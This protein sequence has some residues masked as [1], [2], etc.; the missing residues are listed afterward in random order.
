MKLVTERTDVSFWKFHFSR[1][2][3]AEDV[4]EYGRKK[5]S[6]TTRPHPSR[7]EACL[8]RAISPRCMRYKRAN[9]SRVAFS[10]SSSFFFLPSFSFLLQL[11][12]YIYIV[13]DDATT[14]AASVDEAIYI[15]GFIQPGCAIGPRIS[16]FKVYF[17]S[18]VSFPRDIGYDIGP[19]HGRAWK[20]AAYGTLFWSFRLR[21]PRERT[22]I[23]P[24]PADS[25]AEIP[26]N[27][28]IFSSSVS[29][30]QFH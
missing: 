19:E 29:L 18:F 7:N 22:P 14:L 12:I 30:L 5:N 11:N 2:L 20:M 3:W 25:L 26:F 28:G 23:S 15:D 16:I 27:N 8:S 13:D 6:R 9:F 1:E 10:P 21:Q 17:E 4:S 24:V